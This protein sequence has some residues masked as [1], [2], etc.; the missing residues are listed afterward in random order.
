MYTLFMF[1][2]VRFCNLNPFNTDSDLV[3]DYFIQKTLQRYP[4]PSGLSPVSKAFYSSMTLKSAL[5]STIDPSAYGYSLDDMLISCTF[6]S[7]ACTADDFEQVYVFDYT[8]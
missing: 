7:S 1:C 6:A 2:F 3:V 5:A 4:V 8:K